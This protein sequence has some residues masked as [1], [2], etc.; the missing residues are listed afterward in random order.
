VKKRL[1]IDSS[2]IEFFILIIL[3][4]TSLLY[5]NGC[6][7]KVLQIA[8]D[9][10]SPENTEFWEIKSIV[11]AVKHEND[12]ISVCVGLNE[13]GEAG[14]PILYTISLS[15]PILSGDIDA[16]ER[17]R[18]RPEECLLDNT[19][20][21]WYPKEKTKR[22]CES[23]DL[24]IAS[25]IFVL[26]IENI[27]MNKKNRHQLYHLMIDF[28]KTQPVKER[29]FEV[30]FVFDGEDT[31]K[32]ADKDEVPDNGTEGSKAISLIYWPAQI[33]KRSIQPMIISGVYEDNR[34]DLY[35]LMV[36]LAVVGDLAI[37]I[38]ILALRVT[39]CVMSSGR[40]CE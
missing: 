20:C 10:A 33:D 13:S 15:L 22:G 16:I 34:T 6:T 37:E 3:A 31:E 39:V 24:T 4:M 36:P 28:N 17:L 27:S 14:E 12:D 11:S 35:Y 29:I 2:I 7:D 26:P 23:I 5:L 30:S 40:V 25:S 32:D 1:P 18:L 19:P 21:Y 9:K 8:E 38:S